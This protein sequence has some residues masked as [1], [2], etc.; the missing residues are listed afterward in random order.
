M[1]GCRGGSWWFSNLNV[2]WRAAGDGGA[3]AG[4]EGVD[5]AAGDRRRVWPKQCRGEGGLGDGKLGGSHRRYI[6]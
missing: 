6:D 3:Q 4:V 5:V 2:G 1:D